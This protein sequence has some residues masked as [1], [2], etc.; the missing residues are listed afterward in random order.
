MS[1]IIRYQQAK[2]AGIDDI[3]P[4]FLK[5]CAG[6]IAPLDRKYCIKTDFSIVIWFH[7]RKIIFVATTYVYKHTN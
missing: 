5:Q 2:A 7:E 1:F 4:R 3:D 6:S